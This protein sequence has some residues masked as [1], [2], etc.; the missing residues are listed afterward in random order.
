MPRRKGSNQAFELLKAVLERLPG[1][2]GVG[3]ADAE[4]PGLAG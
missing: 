2:L 3:P 1:T 4:R